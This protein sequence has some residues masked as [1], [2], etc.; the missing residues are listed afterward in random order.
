MEAT[1]IQRQYDEIIADTYDS[2]PQMLTGSTLNLAVEM[3]RNEGILSEILPTLR[4]LDVGMGTGMFLHKLRSATARQIQPFGL[5]ISEKM[6]AVALTKIP[7]LIAEVDDG[8]N[9]AQHFE[10]EQFDLAAT[11]FVT[12]FVPVEDLTTDIFRKLSPGGIWSFVGGTSGGYPALQRC[13]SHP[14]VRFL[15]GGPKQSLQQMICPDSTEQVCRLMQETGF[16]IISSK[17]IQP[18]LDFP[19]FDSFMDFAFRGGWLTPFVEEIG[20]HKIRGWKKWVLNRTFFPLTDHHAI[21][22]IV[23]RRP[24]S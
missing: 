6:I 3:L 16:E 14:V 22:L 17:T 2:D 10:S 5:D 23:A 9:L 1:T 4:V 19:S 11:H 8:A 15:F 13:T 20:L 24:Q 7:D 12:G 18:R 21:S